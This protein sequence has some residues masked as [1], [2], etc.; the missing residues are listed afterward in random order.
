MKTSWQSKNHSAGVIPAL[1][2]SLLEAFGLAPAWRAAVTVWNVPFAI[3]CSIAHIATITLLV[4]HTSY[5]MVLMACSKL[6]WEVL[7]IGTA[8]GSDSAGSI[9]AVAIA[10]FLLLCT[11]LSASLVLL[12][13]VMFHMV[14]VICVRVIQMGQANTFEEISLVLILPIFGNFLFTLGAPAVGHEYARCVK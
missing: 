2:P 11:T 6:Q 8:G 4:K 7:Q 1:F 13:L 10:L 9:C 14:Y 3:C 12:V 5:V